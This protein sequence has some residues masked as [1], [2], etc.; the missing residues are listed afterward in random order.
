[1]PL[2][3]VKMTATATA[4]AAIGTSPGYGRC[5]I[6]SVTA[7]I[8]VTVLVLPSGAAA[9]TRPSLA[10][11]DR[12]MVISSS[13]EKIPTTTQ[14]PTRPSATAW[15]G[16]ES[17]GAGPPLAPRRGGGEPPPARENGPRHSRGRAR[18]D[19][20]RP[21]DEHPEAKHLPWILWRL[22]Q[23]DH[24]RLCIQPEVAGVSA[25]VPARVD[26]RRQQL[27]LIG[28]ERAQ[29]LQS[30]MRRRG[31]LL[32]GEAALATL[33]GEK[34]PHHHSRPILSSSSS[35]SRRFISTSRDFEPW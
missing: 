21:R 24:E 33:G 29:M 2:P 31:R 3:I 28:F 8:C 11:T 6:S 18:E 19:E 30:D 9:I 35:T 5:R 32:K 10:P 7:A 14:A 4:R 25:Q 22:I 34:G 27:R 12:R 20:P 23:P 17:R 16:R 13:R 15:G 26:G 1:M